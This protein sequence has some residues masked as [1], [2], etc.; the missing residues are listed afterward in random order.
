MNAPAAA[1]NYINTLT[2]GNALNEKDRTFF[3]SRMGYDFSG[4]RI[5]AD[6]NANASASSINALAYT[7]E[8]NIVFGAGQYNPHTS[9]GKKLMAHELTHVVQQT[10]NIQRKTACSY[11]KFEHEITG[12]GA[13]VKY[14]KATPDA[15]ADNFPVKL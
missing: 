1:E 15:A 10:G 2:G 13:D 8:N 12:V 7:H 3:E 4:V 5:H 6:S 14:L 9:E 11:E